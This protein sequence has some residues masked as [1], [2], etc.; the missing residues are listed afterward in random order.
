MRPLE[1]IQHYPMFLVGTLLFLG[2]GLF[3]TVYAR[4]IQ[5]YSI[6]SHERHPVI[7]RFNLFRR[8]IYRSGYLLELRLCAVLTFLTGVLCCYILLVG[9]CSDTTGLTNR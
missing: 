1:N 9:R 5:Q 4:R 6:Q 3:V 8:R 7:A 2:F